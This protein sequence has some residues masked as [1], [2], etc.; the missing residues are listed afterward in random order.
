MVWT[1]WQRLVSTVV[2]QSAGALGTHHDVC[3]AKGVDQ[4]RADD[5]VWEREI[6]RNGSRSRGRKGVYTGRL[7]YLAIDLHPDGAVLGPIFVPRDR[8]IGH[9][10]ILPTKKV[11]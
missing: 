6:E 7:S 8:N 2:T 4:S 10:S 1:R 9:R 11:L 5:R 3:C